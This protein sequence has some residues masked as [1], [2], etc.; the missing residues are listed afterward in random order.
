[1]LKENQLKEPI[2]TEPPALSITGQVREILEE[3]APGAAKRIKELVQCKD[4]GVALRASQAIL[5]KVIPDKIDNPLQFLEGY[6]E[7]QLIGIIAG[8]GI[9][10]GGV[11]VAPPIRIAEKGKSNGRSAEAK[12]TE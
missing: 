5:D 3:A 2:R 8:A 6:T 1:M 12:G 10:K 11:I 9:L 7:D 4:P